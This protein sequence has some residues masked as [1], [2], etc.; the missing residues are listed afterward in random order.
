MFS[1]HMAMR[2]IIVH[3]VGSPP[4]DGAARVQDGAIVSAAQARGFAE[5]W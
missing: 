2:N 5:S 4:A 3:G 1:Y